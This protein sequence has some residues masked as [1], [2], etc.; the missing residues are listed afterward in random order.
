MVQLVIASLM[1]ILTV[2]LHLGGLSALMALVQRASARGR[3]PRRQ[4]DLVV[5]ALVIFLAAIGLFVLHTVEIWAYAGLYILLG[6]LHGFEESLYFSTAT[7]T[8]LGYGDVTLGTRW[9]I[10]GAIE[11]ANGLI[12]L[13]WSTAFFI[14]IVEQIKRLEREMES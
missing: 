14:S 1:V 6:A 13:G 4:H 3:P 7:Y 2:L 8:T 5:K 10:L 9:R 12:L 11:G